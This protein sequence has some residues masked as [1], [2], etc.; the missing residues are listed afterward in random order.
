MSVNSTNVSVIQPVVLLI[1]STFLFINPLF[2]FGIFVAD[3]DRPLFN[4]DYALVVF[5]VFLMRNKSIGY[6]IPLILI[7]FFLFGIDLIS[8]ISTA[9]VFASFSDIINLLQYIR[10]ANQMTI[11]V[12]ILGIIWVLLSFWLMKKIFSYATGLKLVKEGQIL[13]C[14]LAILLA[15]AGEVRLKS[16]DYETI[17]SNIENN[18]KYKADTSDWMVARVNPFFG[19]QTYFMY[20][21]MYSGFKYA[22]SQ[23]LKSF[24]AT[25]PVAAKWPRLVAS[26]AVD[27][28]MDKRVILIVVESFGMPKDM[29]DFSLMYPSLNKF[30]S[31][32]P[33]KAVGS[34]WTQGVT[35]TNEIRELCKIHLLTPDPTYIK[36]FSGCLPYKMQQKGTK[37]VSLVVSSGG[38]YK[39]NNWLKNAGFDESIFLENAGDIGKSYSFPA[40]EDIKL[41][42][43]LKGLLKNNPENLFVYWMTSNS[44]F[45]YDKRDT[46]GSTYPCSDKQSEQLCNYLKIHN[47]FFDALYEVIKD[48]KNLKIVITGDHMPPFLQRK[49]Q[50]YFEYEFVP[51]VVIKL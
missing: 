41:M 20:R 17:K 9:Y 40:G 10:Y 12:L 24:D 14:L 36:D 23:M 45:P 44:H 26:D 37:T 7:T 3:Y 28:E 30:A 29:N 1:I 51:G 43:R 32:I 11:F 33:S 5:V 21:S 47:K 49:D 19:S 25:S 6:F 42:P 46:M 48:E 15:V 4:M 31:H 18:V 50:A 22:Q 2:W 34:I 39:Y 16:T 13:F 35:I 8:V 38:M 27:I